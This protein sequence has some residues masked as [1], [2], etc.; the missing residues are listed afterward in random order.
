MKPISVVG[1]GL[2]APGQGSPEAWLANRHELETTRPACAILNPRIGRFTSLMTRVSVEVASQACAGSRVGLREVPTL[3]GSAHGEIQIAFELL[4]MIELDGVPSPARFMNSVHNAASGHVSISA[5]NTLFS[6]ALAAGT[7]TFAMCLL[8][9]WAWLETA[10]GSIVVVVADEPLP[11]H[12]AGAGH[13][14][15]LG[16]AFHLATEPL[17]AKTMGSLSSLSRR[18]PTESPGSI[19]DRLAGNPCAAALCLV[20]AV[21]RERPGVVPVEIGGEGWS[22]ELGIPEE[23]AA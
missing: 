18:S 10:G 1:I 16:V 3:F 12:L 4:D 13:Y 22:I 23:A 2:W 9:A 20:E 11:D 7:R 19:P 15:A 21:L 8:E 5:G 14:D 6:T 17:P